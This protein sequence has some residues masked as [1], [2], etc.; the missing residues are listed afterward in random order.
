[1]AGGA[2]FARLYATLEGRTGPFDAAV[3][4][5]H[6]RLAAFGGTLSR[7]GS[8]AIKA[9]AGLAV[10]GVGAFVAGI[11]YSI[12][13]ASDLNETLSKVGEVFGGS[14]GQVTGF[15]QKMADSFGL[16]KGEILDAAANIGLVG[17]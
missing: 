13:R 12:K 4:R 3:D 14:T 6:Q 1:M 8:L 10:A 9:F 16:N 15:A 5:S 7:V 17:E 2:E 11:G